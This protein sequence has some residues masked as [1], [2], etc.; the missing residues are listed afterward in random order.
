MSGFLISLFS[1]IGLYCKKV[2][3][4][5]KEEKWMHKT[6]ITESQKQRKHKKQKQKREREEVV[7]MPFKLRF[8]NSGSTNT[9]W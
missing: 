4:E 8:N 5:M 6:L 9:F 2:L 3:P 7:D 1:Y